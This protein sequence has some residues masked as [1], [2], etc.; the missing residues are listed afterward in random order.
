ML[1]TAALGDRRQEDVETETGTP[2]DVFSK[3]K[4][5]KYTYPSSVSDCFTECVVALI[6]GL[7]S[8]RETIQNYPN[9]QPLTPGDKLWPGFRQ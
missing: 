5:N 9:L 4:T 7:T 6:Y 2:T 3:A 1:V 8:S